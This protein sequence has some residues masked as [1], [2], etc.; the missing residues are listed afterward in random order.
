MPAKN[1]FRSYNPSDLLEHLP[2]EDLAFDGKAAPLFFIQ[3]D[4]SFPQLLPQH[5]IFNQE[6]FDPILLPTIDPASE[7]QK[8]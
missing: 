2:T 3:Q 5:T 4:S 8:Q 1:R 6:L 7:N